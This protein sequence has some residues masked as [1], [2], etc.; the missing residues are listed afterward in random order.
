M[1]SAASVR[2]SRTA[3]PLHCLVRC[4][5]GDGRPPRCPSPPSS[6]PPSTTPGA[7][8]AS[9]GRGSQRHR[10]S[11]RW[12]RRGDVSP[13]AI[14]RTAVN[15]PSCRKLAA[16]TGGCLSAAAVAAAAAACGRRWRARRRRRASDGVG[17]LGAG[18][19][20]GSDGWRICRSD[21][22]CGRTTFSL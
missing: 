13:M 6:M 8:G 18:T 22:L 15:G 10:S 9:G 11:R 19:G 3:S 1:S 20:T 12:A 16:V 4:R 17:E 21:G 2:L 5:G 14:S 7:V